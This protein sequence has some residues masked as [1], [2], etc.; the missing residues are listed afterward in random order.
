MKQKQKKTIK[1]HTLFGY[2]YNSVTEFVNDLKN[3]PVNPIFTDCQ[4]SLSEESWYK[5]FTATDNFS[6]AQDLLKYGDTANMQ[7]MS[8]AGL[9]VGTVKSTGSVPRA[10]RYNSV[11]GFCPNVPRYLQGAPANMINVRRKVFKTSKVVNVFFNLS[12]PG[13]TS[14]NDIVDT[15]VAFVNALLALENKGYRV[16][17]YAGKASFESGSGQMFLCAVKIKDSAT[18]FDK[19][20]I[21]YPLINPSFQRRHMFRALE[22]SEVTSSH[23]AHGYGYPA[24]GSDK[25]EVN[26]ALKQTGVNCDTVVCLSDI[27]G[28]SSQDILNRCFSS[29]K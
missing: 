27:L 9:N 28:W 12:V 16:N 14:A 17:L 10:Q 5:D 11:V 13:N 2:A 3:K 19:K 20:K 29:R 15:N 25:E 23:W 8:A 18:F 24:T 1:N 4:K 7:K 26:D 6:V 21:A 22:V